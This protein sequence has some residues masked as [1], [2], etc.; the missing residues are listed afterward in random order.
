MRKLHL[1]MCIGVLIIIASTVGC[2]R[3]ATVEGFASRPSGFGY[4][5]DNRYFGT[6]YRKRVYTSW[7]YGYTTG[8]RDYFPYRK[9]ETVHNYEYHYRWLNRNFPNRNLRM[10]VHD[11]KRK[12]YTKYHPDKHVHAIMQILATDRLYIRLLNFR[13]DEHI[14]VHIDELSM[15]KRAYPYETIRITVEQYVDTKRWSNARHDTRLDTHI[16][17]YAKQLRWRFRMETF[18]NEQVF[19]YV[20]H[21]HTNTYVLEPPNALMIDVFFKMYPISLSTL[22][23][24]RLVV[25]PIIMLPN[26]HKPKTVSRNELQSMLDKNLARRKEE[27]RIRSFNNLP[28]KDISYLDKKGNKKVTFDGNVRLYEYDANDVPKYYDTNA[29]GVALQTNPFVSGD[30][31][32][33][34]VV[35]DSNVDTTFRNSKTNFKKPV[36]ITNANTTI[37]KGRFLDLAHFNDIRANGNI[38]FY[39]RSKFNCISKS[40]VE[41]LS[42]TDAINEQLGKIRSIRGAC[43][44]ESMMTTNSELDNSFSLTDDMICKDE[45]S[46]VRKLSNW[47]DENA[48]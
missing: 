22:Q 6:R 8:S 23:N 4:V 27:A 3:S 28:T 32:D 14:P 34:I 1:I 36:N 15:F 17:D 46:G 26:D 40:D 35:G 10:Y 18:R 33:N 12:V 31:D 2:M 48:K 44:S 16:L 42:D 37:N 11:P 5:K 38:C 24:N 45:K 30:D 25:V 29:E 43:T 20:F 39:D 13:Q 41:Q 19:I 21:K 9:N 7:A 47:Y